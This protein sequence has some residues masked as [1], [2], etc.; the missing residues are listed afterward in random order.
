MTK[1]HHNSECYRSSYNKSSIPVG[2]FGEFLSR[3]I[4][5]KL[6]MQESMSRNSAAEPKMKTNGEK[7]RLCESKLPLSQQNQSKSTSKNI[8]RL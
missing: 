2:L 3:G 8:F 1:K 7:N 5:S 4:F 6:K